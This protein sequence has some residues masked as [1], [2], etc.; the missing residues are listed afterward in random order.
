MVKPVWRDRNNCGDGMNPR[1]IIFEDEDL[2][3]IALKRVLLSK[4]FEVFSYSNPTLFLAAD[5]ICPHELRQGDFLLTDNHMPNMSGL[6]FIEKQTELGCKSMLS[7]KAVMS[8]SW[9]DENLE[10]AKS[11]GCKIFHKPFAITEI[12][13]WLDKQKTPI[14]LPTNYSAGD[15]S[16]SNL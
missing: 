6:D 9:S 14:R 10:K 2:V 4:G 16:V 5:E 3:R 12:L 11:L 7:N 1:I 13:D 8:A 15:M